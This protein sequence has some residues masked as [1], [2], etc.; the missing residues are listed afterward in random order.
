MKHSEVR[1]TI[2]DTAARLFYHNGYNLTGIN[3][4][5]KEAGIAKATLYNHFRSKDEICI[6]YLRS[7]NN[8][9]LVSIENYVSQ[10]PQG[11]PQIIALFNFLEEF[12]RADDFNG[13]WCVNTISEIPKE[14]T[15]IRAEIQSQKQQFLNLIEALMERNFEANSSAE[16]LAYARH[17]YLLYEGAISESYLHQDNWPIETAKVL[18]EKLIA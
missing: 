18:C 8:P 14:K 15:E 4:I 16:N 7:K 5:I 3:E 9:F 2:V 17:I 11:K 1:Q 6:A 13:C 12:Y 10:A